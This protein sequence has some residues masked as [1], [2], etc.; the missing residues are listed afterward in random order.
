VLSGNPVEDISVL[1]SSNKYICWVALGNCID[2]LE[3]VGA[4]GKSEDPIIK[5]GI[6]P[7]VFRRFLNAVESLNNIVD[8]LY[9]DKYHERFKS[10]GYYKAKLLN[11]YPVIFKINEIAN[12]YKHCERG[13][14]RND[15]FCSDLNKLRSKDIRFDHKILKEAFKF[16]LE[17]HQKDGKVDLFE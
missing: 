9:F 12:A 2:Y 3:E 17:Y 16:W 11:K 7:K 5:S 14:D 15:I 8:Y 13:K 4:L 6:S 1:Y 10:F